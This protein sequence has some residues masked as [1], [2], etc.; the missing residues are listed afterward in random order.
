MRKIVEEKV[1]EWEGKRKEM[2]LGQG[3]GQGEFP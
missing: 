2:V 1:P 3:G